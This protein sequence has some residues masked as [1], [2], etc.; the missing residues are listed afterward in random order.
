MNHLELYGADERRY[1]EATLYPTL[2]LARVLTQHKDLYRIATDEVECMAEVSGNLRLIAAQTE[3]WPAVGDFIMCDRMDDFAGNAI[4]HTI[5]PR[6]TSFVRRAAG[7][8][9][10]L[11]TVAANIDVVFLCMALNGDFNESR[12]E[13]YLSVAWASGATPVVVLTKA[14][15]CENAD[16]AIARIEPVSPGTE[17]IAVSQ[18]DEQSRKHLRDYLTPGTTASFLGS[19]GVGKST[20]INALAGH[21][22]LSTSTTRRDDKGRH[23]TT[24]RQLVVLPDGGI[25]IDTPGMR[26]LGVDTV[27]LSR[28]FSDIDD[29]AHLC[30]FRDCGHTTE[31]GCAV[32]QALEEGAL[33]NRRLE[34]YRK[35]QREA[36]YDGLTSRQIETEK[37]D[38]MFDEAGGMKKARKFIREN[39]K[40]KRS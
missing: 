17:V 9:R 12:I 10:K 4:I 8:S 37:L 13:R 36:H 23:T 31:P 14:D 5:L 33:D 1:R 39:D 24:S 26:E 27:D 16:A 19:S 35:L 22:L 15:L 25:V 34:N 38:T 3:D 20:L 21:E 11:Q 30:R 18:S 40:R 2:H 28:S 32:R 6:R 7:T 29:L